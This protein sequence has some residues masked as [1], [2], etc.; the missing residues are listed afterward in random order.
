[1][2]NASAEEITARQYM[3]NATGALGAAAAAGG[4]NA[5]ALDLLKRGFSGVTPEYYK[6]GDKAKLPAALAKAGGTASSLEPPPVSDLDLVK[7]MDLQK[8]VGQYLAAGGDETETLTPFGSEW[9]ANPLDGDDTT[10]GDT[11]DPESFREWTR[12]P[13]KSYET[14]TREDARR[15]RTA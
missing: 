10:R 14:L 7:L 6:R 11:Y 12:N 15:A 3:E 9:V 1:G 8:G 5:A 13:R 2:A 4:S